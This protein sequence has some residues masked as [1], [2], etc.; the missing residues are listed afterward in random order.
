[1]R[2]TAM[3]PWMSSTEIQ[4]VLRYLKS[5][6]AML[7]YGSGGSTLLFPE[8]VDK[9]FSIE[10]DEKWYKKVKEQCK[11]NSNVVIKHVPRDHI[12]PDE[13]RIKA[14]TWQELDT[15][16]RAKD[17]KTYIEYPKVFERK[18]DVVLVD[19]RA[20]PECAKFIKDYLVDDGYLFMH[21][22]WP[23]CRKAY[24]V[25]EEHYRVIDKVLTGQGLAVF[26]KRI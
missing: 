24:R 20:R 5:Y 22:Y 26:R 11:S 13:N 17:F 8:Y 12:T 15:S 10:H 25:V 7:E 4:T 18:F 23:D 3:Q 21:D 9:Y 16:S 6:Q 1:M 19:G 14:T 2:E